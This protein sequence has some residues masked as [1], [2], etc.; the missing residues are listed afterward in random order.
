VGYLL[1]VEDDEA[2]RRTLVRF[3]RSHL[4]VRSAS[5]ADEAI[6]QLGRHDDWSGFLIDVALGSS[7]RAGLDL[8]STARRVFPNVPAALVTG[9][10]DRTVINHAARHAATFLCKPYGPRELAS[11]LERV[12]A[13]EVALDERLRGRLHALARKWSLT[14]KETEL[15]AW[16]LAGR[17]RKS[18]LERP[19]ASASAWSLHVGGLLAKANAK[20]TEDLLYAI[21]REENRAAARAGGDSR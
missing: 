9:S 12:V 17:T 4:P 2:A 15:L 5:T 14:P 20:R 13:A 16:L 11:F 3:L 10:T 1:V 7:P 6:S 18:Y 21:L 19:G 8:L